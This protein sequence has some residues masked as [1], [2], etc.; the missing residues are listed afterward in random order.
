[1]NQRFIAESSVNIKPSDQEFWWRITN[2]EMDSEDVR[3]FAQLTAETGGTL[4]R[5]F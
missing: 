1:M 2:C 5:D 3:P 4:W